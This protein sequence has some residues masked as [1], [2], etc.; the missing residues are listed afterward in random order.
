MTFVVDLTRF[1]D[2]AMGNVEKAVRYAGLLAAQGVVMMSPVGNPDLWKSKPPPGYVGGRF[3]A[4]WTFGEGQAD[5]STSE[6]IDPSGAQTLSR[7]QG[8]IAAA[9]VGTVW[10]LANSLPYAYRLEFEGWSSQ[11]PAGFVRVT[12]ADLARR[13]EAYAAKLR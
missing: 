6:Q 12:A 1:R 9:Q 7:L 2:K 4:N 10:Y 3:R 8:E 5:L 11:A 13:V